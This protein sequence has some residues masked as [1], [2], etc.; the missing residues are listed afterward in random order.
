M[1]K[2]STVI[3]NFMYLIFD[4]LFSRYIQN[5]VLKLM[6]IIIF[7]DNYLYP[8]KNGYNFASLLNAFFHVA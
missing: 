3:S 7:D 6:I 4:I 1:I 5:V 2:K 8:S